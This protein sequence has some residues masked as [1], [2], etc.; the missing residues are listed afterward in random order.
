MRNTNVIIAIVLVGSVVLLFSGLGLMGFGQGGM[1]GR[2]GLPGGYGMQGFGV[3]PFGMLM[4]LVFLALL[5]G[6]GVLLVLRLARSAGHSPSM[7]LAGETP[8]DT[9]KLRYAKGEL[10]KEQFE[11]SKRT[12]GV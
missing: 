11:D 4:P 5:I 1:M 6:G 3:S 9:L 7:A 8:L 2:Y 10:T 12:L